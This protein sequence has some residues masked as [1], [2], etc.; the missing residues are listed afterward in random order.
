M[1]FRPIALALL[2][3]ATGC[4]RIYKVNTAPLDI[5]TKA[6]AAEKMDPIGRVSAKYCNSLIV[7]IPIFQNP[8]KVFDG[9]MDEA[10]AQGGTAVTDVKLEGVNYVNAPL[11]VKMCFELSGTAVKPH[12]EATPPPPPPSKKKK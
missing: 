11:Y 12:V 6:V 10:K 3:V 8:S 4:T 1:S 5:S 9:L 7:I 2:L